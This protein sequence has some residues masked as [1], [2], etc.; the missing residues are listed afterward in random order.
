M[1]LLIAVPLSA[2]YVICYYLSSSILSKLQQGYSEYEV[3]YDRIPCVA[4]SLFYLQNAIYSNM[5]L[6][7]TSDYGMRL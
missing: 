3:F 4:D 6:S 7:P 1:I 2:F 5:S